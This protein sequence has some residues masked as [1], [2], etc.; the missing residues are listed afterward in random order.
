MNSMVGLKKKTFELA[1]KL[2]KECDGLEIIMFCHIIINLIQTSSD[3]VQ[4]TFLKF[5]NKIY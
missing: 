2:I 3:L 5:Q 4:G 1:C